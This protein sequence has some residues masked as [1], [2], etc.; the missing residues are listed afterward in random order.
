MS[1]VKPLVGI[2][3]G[4]TSDWPTM[5]KAAEI[6]NALEVAYEAKIVSAHR[7]PDRLWS[8]GKTAAERGIKVIIAGAGGAGAL[9][10]ARD[11]GPGFRGL[12]G[13]WSTRRPC[14][15]SP[16]PPTRAG[17]GNHRRR[18]SGDG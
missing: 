9:P 10:G 1:E 6:L 18:G 8:Y 4:S 15:P 3:M 5:E 16:L 11:W 13:R 7:T 14:R 17:R 2:I 12:P